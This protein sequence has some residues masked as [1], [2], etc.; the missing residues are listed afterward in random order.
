MNH[1]R[2]VLA[3]GLA[4]S[5]APA[6]PAPV[7][8]PTGGRP[9]C[10][11]TGLTLPTGFC[12]TVVT[13]LGT[14]ARHLVVTPS[15]DIFVATIGSPQAPSSIVALRDTDGDGRADLRENFG[16]GSG[17]GIAWRDGSLWFGTNDAI[18]RYRIAAGSL[19]P[20][21]G[22]DTIVSGLRADSGH[23]AKTIAVS[24]D[25]RLYVNIGSPTNACQER[26]RQAG[27]RGTDPCG[28]LET[29]AGIWLF[30]ANRV[31]QTQRDG[32]RFASG[33]RNAVGLTVHPQT[34]TLFVMQHGRDNLSS[35]WPALFTDQQNAE[36]PAEEMFRVTEGTDYGWPY[37]YYDPIL[38]SKVLAPEYGGDGKTVG[39]CANVGQ[40]IVVF[41]AHWAPNAIAFYDGTQFPVR[42]RG[43]AFIAFHGSWNRAPLPQAGYNVAFVPFAGERPDGDYQIFADD[44][45]GP[46]KQPRGATTRPTGLAVGPDGS[47]YISDTEQGR[48]WRITWRG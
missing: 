21:S 24:A 35:N 15:G 12:A 16:P 32:R 7:V 26:D 33:I 19:R 28:A 17:S 8:S 46:N 36:I 10:D 48:I 5:C 40:P 2:T 14:R 37:C 43:G 38:K 25:G 11:S 41:P 6:T 45:A 39:R 47:L 34:G 1:M 30:D 29:R 31:G 4:L 18:V 23:A 42:Y 27:S 44:F 22:P 20:S 3:A 9:A 13:S